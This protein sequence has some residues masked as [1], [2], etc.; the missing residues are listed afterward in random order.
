MR[1]TEWI[2]FGCGRCAPEEWSNY[3]SSPS[4]RLEKLPLIGGL[5]PTGPYGRFPMNVLYGDIVRGL[6]VAP[7]T[8]DLLYCSHVLEHLS[9]ADLRTAL[10]N[11]HDMLRKG[12]VFRLVLPDIE[13]MIDQYRNDGSEQ[14]ALRFMENTLLG[15]KTRVR[16]F[17]GFVRSW[18]GNSHHLWM[19]DYKA[20]AAELRAAGFSNVRRAGYNDSHHEA[21][22]L[23]ETPDRW[24]HELGIEC[25]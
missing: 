5:V 25:S 21:F 9:L 2:H 13:Y 24:D 18:L 7:G 11:C 8:V 23:V 4:L 17:R 19:W 22:R 3:D 6:Q 20:F 14:A 10:R 12:G 15:Q 16:G 1:H